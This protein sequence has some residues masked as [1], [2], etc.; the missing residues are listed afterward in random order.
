M[1]SAVA[2]LIGAFLENG[3][4]ITKCPD[5][6]GLGEP[7]A[8]RARKHGA[9]EH[10]DHRGLCLIGNVLQGKKRRAHTGELVLAALALANEPLTLL[11][12]EKATGVDFDRLRGVVTALALDGKII[13]SPRATRQ[14]RF[15]SLAISN[16]DAGRVTGGPASDSAEVARIGDNP[17]S[18]ARPGRA[19]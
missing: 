15:F 2:E 18:S 14:T 6:I 7:V 5:G 11:G 10:I 3:G 19:A 17:S 12:I 1:R 16:T 8:K 9:S 4:K 13:I